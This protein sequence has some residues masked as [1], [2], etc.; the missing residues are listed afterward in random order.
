MQ[1]RESAT[2]CRRGFTIA[3]VME[4]LLSLSQTFR[5]V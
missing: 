5:Q 1:R 2:I 4:S 3:I